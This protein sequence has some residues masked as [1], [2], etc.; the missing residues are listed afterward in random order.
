[1]VFVVFRRFVISAWQK[2]G[3]W[4]AAMFAL[5]LLEQWGRGVCKN[6]VACFCVV[7]VV[8]LR[9]QVALGLAPCEF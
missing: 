3:R 8:V 9:F 1:M 2:G 6:L 5:R 4:L 7:F